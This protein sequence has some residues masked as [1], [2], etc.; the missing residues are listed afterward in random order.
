V[1]S[2]AGDADHGDGQS[3][4]G[5]GLFLVGEQ[6]AADKEAGGAGGAGLDEPATRQA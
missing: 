5:S 6:L 3:V 2:L 1:G 4:V